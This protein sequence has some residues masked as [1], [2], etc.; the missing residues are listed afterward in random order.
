MN[1]KN[2]S[3]HG[4]GAA[5][6]HLFDLALEEERSCGGKKVSRAHY[7]TSYSPSEDHEELAPGC[8]WLRG[9]LDCGGSRP[10][11]APDELELSLSDLD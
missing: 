4:A 7:L 8:F 3:L 11:R 9:G 10:E 5:L 6:S 1:K 2:T